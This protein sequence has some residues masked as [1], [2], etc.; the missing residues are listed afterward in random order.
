MKRSE[1]V[2]CVLA[3][4]SLLVFL[5]DSPEM[6]FESFPM[7]IVFSVASD[8]STRGLED[9]P[10]NG[11]ISSDE[12]I[13]ILGKFPENFNRTPIR[14]MLKFNINVYIF[15]DRSSR[16]LW[17]DLTANGEL[18]SN[19][20]RKGRYCIRHSGRMGSGSNVF[21]MF[22]SVSITTVMVAGIQAFLHV[23]S[24]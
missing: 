21:L 7:E 5:V 10:T 6:G 14:A 3:G 19:Y 4:K 16:T 23:Q 20:R 12:I 18:L 8:S 24:V 9:S 15:I 22:Q 11:T 13:L 17:T 2:P 1:C